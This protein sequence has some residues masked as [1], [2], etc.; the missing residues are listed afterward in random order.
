MSRLTASEAKN[1]AETL[2]SSRYAEMKDM[3]DTSIR[4]A[5]EKGEFSITLYEEIP[6]EVVFFYRDLGYKVQGS[7]YRN[8]TVFNISWR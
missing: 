6:E 1:I 2:N 4:N 8:E 5:C 7:S 3:I